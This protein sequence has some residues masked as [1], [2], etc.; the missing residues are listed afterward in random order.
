MR[1]EPRTGLV[2]NRALALAAAL[3]L[4]AFAASGA[5]AQEDEAPEA[6]A[7]DEATDDAASQGAASPDG[8][9]GEGASE[10]RE[11][12]ITDDGPYAVEACFDS[13][14]VRDFDAFDDRY[15]Y[16]RVG[17]DEH[18][19]LTMQRSC[20]GLRNAFQIGIADRFSRICSNT[21]ASIVYGAFGREERCPIR[22][23]E[24]VDGKEAA[25]AIAEQRRNE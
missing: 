8:A 14:S 10:V 23:V 5:S 21:F 13:R 11:I 12:D 18:Y 22:R 15:V 3:W 17:R 9:S 2:G 4:G 25:I 7:A 19:L 20:I 24:A 16:L 6:P 1:Y